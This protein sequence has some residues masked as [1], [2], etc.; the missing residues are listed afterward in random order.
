MPKNAVNHLPG[1]ITRSSSNV[2]A[3]YS[4]VLA[5]TVTGFRADRH[6]ELSG[7]A[8][9]IAPRRYQLHRRYNSVAWQTTMAIRHAG[10]AVRRD[11]AASFAEAAPFAGLDA[12]DRLV[13]AIAVRLEHGCLAFADIEPV[14]AKGIHDVRLVR[15]DHGVAAGR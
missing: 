7:T 5:R 8:R 12:D 10:S 13:A 14:L 9:Q 3:C 1:F 4:A 11:G 15:D 6:N 2:P